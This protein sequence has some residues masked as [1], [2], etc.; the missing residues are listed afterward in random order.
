M[1]GM[2]SDCSSLEVLDLSSFNTNKVTHMSW[3]FTHC[4]KLKKLDLSSFNT[5]QLTN[6]S[7]MFDSVNKLCKLKCEDE[8]IKNEFKNETGCLI[9]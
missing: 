8:K 9:I 5:N 4:S 7:N 2:F 3:M 1:S 6:L